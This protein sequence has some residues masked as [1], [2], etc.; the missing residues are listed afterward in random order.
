MEVTYSIAVSIS[1]SLKACDEL[2]SRVGIGT[3]LIGIS[4]V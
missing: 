4:D 2:K 3:L 1:D